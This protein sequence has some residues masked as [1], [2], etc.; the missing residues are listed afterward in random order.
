MIH[1]K[2]PKFIKLVTGSSNVNGLSLFCF[3]VY[4]DKL[5]A[6]LKNHEEIHYRQCLEGFV[7]GFWII[8]F[9]YIFKVG[10]WN[11]PYEKEAYANEY[12]LEYLKKRK[13][14][15]WLKYR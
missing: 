7:I 4:K 11:N 9:Y 13:F 8:Y 6:R 14:W 2:A 12:D 3:L 1:V 15:A 10:Y 5:T